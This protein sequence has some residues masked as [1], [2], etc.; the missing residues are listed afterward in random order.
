MSFLACSLYTGIAS[1]L[2]DKVSL[3]D[4]SPVVYI[5]LSSGTPAA[6]IS[7]FTWVGLEG[8]NFQLMPRRVLSSSLFSSFCCCNSLM[9]L[10]AAS[11][12]KSSPSSVMS[13]Q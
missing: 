9:Y 7:I 1:L 3:P 11:L 13:K 12:L 4:F 8:S 10:V 2:V 5:N 6:C